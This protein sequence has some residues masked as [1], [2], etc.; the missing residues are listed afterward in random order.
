MT[1]FI[2]KLAK[3]LSK[4]S[5]KYLLLLLFI[6]IISISCLYHVFQVTL[7]YLRFE[8]KIDFSIN[9][10]DLKIPMISFCRNAFYQFKDKKRPTYGLTPAQV[11]NETFSF[12]DI[13][14]RMNYYYYNKRFKDHTFWHVTNFKRHETL[15]NSEDFDSKTMIYIEKTFT[16]YTVCYNFKH[17]QDKLI[18][19][20][21]ISGERKILKFYLYNHKYSKYFVAERY[22]L[23]LSGNDYDIIDYNPFKISRNNFSIRCLIRY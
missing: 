12:G 3:L 15:V 16:D 17:F 18:K 5:Y 11:Y 13:F 10:N 1:K 20:K 9:K 4:I 23:F 8:T 21:W 22:E 14:L 7:I 2:S 6:L 19:P